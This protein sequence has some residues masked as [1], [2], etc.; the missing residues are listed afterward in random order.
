MDGA[1]LV[2]AVD[3]ADR[4]VDIDRQASI[5]GTAPRRQARVWIS[6]VAASSWRTWP[7][8]N[9]RRNVTKRRVVDRPEVSDVA[10]EVDAVAMS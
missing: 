6:A 10:G 9:D 7:N 3:F 2:M 8:V 4:R 5:A 1:L